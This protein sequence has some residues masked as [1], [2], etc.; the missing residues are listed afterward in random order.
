MRHPENPPG[1][2]CPLPHLLGQKRGMETGAAGLQA[3]PWGL[4]KDLG[5]E[6][7]SLPLPT[8]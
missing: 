7:W 2:P 1:H 3:H 5:W 6:N 8:L 4:D